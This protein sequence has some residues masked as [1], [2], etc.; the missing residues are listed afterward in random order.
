[1][2][3]RAAFPFPGRQAKQT[4]RG[5]R[6]RRPGRGH[7]ACLGAQ[8][9][10]RTC[11]AE[12]CSTEPA[13]TGGLARRRTRQPQRACVRR[14]RSIDAVLLDASLACAPEQP[15]KAGPRLG[16]QQYSSVHGPTLTVKLPGRCVSPEMSASARARKRW[17][18]SL[19]TG[20][21]LCCWQIPEYHSLANASPQPCQPGRPRRSRASVRSTASR[22][23]FG[24]QPV[25]HSWSQR[26]PDLHRPGRAP[27]KDPI[28]A[29][30][31]S[32]ISQPGLNSEARSQRSHG[33]GATHAALELVER[34]PAIHRRALRTL[35]SPARTHGTAPA[36]RHARL[37]RGRNGRVR[38]SVRATVA[39]LNTTMVLG[40]LRRH[41]RMLAAWLPFVASRRVALQLELAG[42]VVGAP[43]EY[44][45]HWVGVWRDQG[46]LRSHISVS[47]AAPARRRNIGPQVRPRT[48]WCAP[49][50]HARAERAFYPLLTWSASGRRGISGSSPAARWERSRRRA[51]GRQ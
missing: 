18:M 37:G 40:F 36:R 30:T 48:A 11:A 32:T 51:R 5:R 26:Q 3:S 44:A 7:F 12:V 15:A 8:R 1:M 14:G 41:A 39:L 2:R 22:R 33:L 23:S 46:A 25:N 19:P 9:M 42:L 6:S 27:P 16:T 4:S 47:L 20:R 29:A 13:L 43:A 21:G 28:Q 49:S 17:R 35:A 24:R 50:P 31:E 10:Q 34:A 45:E 38:G